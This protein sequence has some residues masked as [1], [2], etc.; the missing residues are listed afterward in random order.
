MRGILETSLETSNAASTNITVR[1]STALDVNTFLTKEVGGLLQDLANLLVNFFFV[2]LSNPVEDNKNGSKKNQPNVEAE[3]KAANVFCIV[4][5]GLSL[6]D[7]SFSTT[8]RADS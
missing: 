8:Q 1:V 2:F 3:K 4:S 6:S 7:F 5:L